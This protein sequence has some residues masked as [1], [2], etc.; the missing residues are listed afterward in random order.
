MISGGSLYSRSGLINPQLLTRN[1]N[2]S[3]GKVNLTGKQ[4]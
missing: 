1:F 4:M 3:T 2:H